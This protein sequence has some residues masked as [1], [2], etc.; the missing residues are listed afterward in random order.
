MYHG[1]SDARSF[2]HTALPKSVRPRGR[3]QA[4]TKKKDGRANT[5][6]PPPTTGEE[7]TTTL[8]T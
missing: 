8:R 2:R 6:N 5:L 3:D 4:R 7:S 1:R